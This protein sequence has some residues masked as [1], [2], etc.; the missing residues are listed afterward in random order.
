MISSENATFPAE[1]KNTPDRKIINFFFIFSF[2][3]ITHH[4]LDEFWL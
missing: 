1:K 3:S 2:L 4:P